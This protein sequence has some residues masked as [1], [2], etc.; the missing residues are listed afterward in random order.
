MHVCTLVQ[1]EQEAGRSEQLTLFPAPCPLDTAAG[2]KGERLSPSLAH[3]PFLSPPRT[4]HSL[5]LLSLW[6]DSEFRISSRDS[7][8]CEG[9]LQIG[10]A[11]FGA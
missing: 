6:T 2:T 7:R 10:G 9:R 5:D 4:R 1:I 3:L 11:E 8:V